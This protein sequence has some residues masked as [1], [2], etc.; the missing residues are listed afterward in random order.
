MKEEFSDFLLNSSANE[1]LSNPQ[2]N[3]IEA[4]QHHVCITE[5]DG[6]MRCWGRAIMD[7]LDMAVLQIKY[8]QLIIKRITEAT[9]KFIKYPWEVNIH[10]QLME[11]MNCFVGVIAG[12]IKMDTTI[13]NI[14]THTSS[15]MEPL[16]IH[17]TPLATISA[18]ENYNCAIKYDSNVLVLGKKYTWS[19]WPWN[20]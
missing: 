7:R 16:N 3:S 15:G 10:V 18:G 6:G 13:I 20:N 8:I 5:S 11:M 19:D 12:S 14:N 1:I 2:V 17:Y 9:W 4:G